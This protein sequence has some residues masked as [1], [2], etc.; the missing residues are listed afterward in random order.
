MYNGIDLEI[1]SE[2]ETNKQEDLK[3]IS[4]RTPVLLVFLRHFG[5]VFCKE[6]LD[7]LSEKR[8]VIE[9]KGIQMVFVHMS[10]YDVA[11]AYFKRY[12]LEG[13]THISDPF[14]NY[15]AAFGITKGTFSQL[16][17]LRTWIRGFAANRQGH[18]LELA[19]RLGDSTQ[20]PGIFVLKNGEIKDRFIHKL[21]SDRPDYDKIIERCASEA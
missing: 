13:A 8:Q 2:M 19:K 18:E 17:G 3:T 1:L 4:D 11:D 15:Y 10:E 7:E 20:M 14:C 12:D 5:C 6:A 21:P 9:E 16:Y